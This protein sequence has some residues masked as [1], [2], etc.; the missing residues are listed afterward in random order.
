MTT[1]SSATLP[2]IN[3]RQD[4]DMLRISLQISVFGGVASSAVS[5]HTLTP[6]PLT[7]HGM[8]C[9]LHRFHTCTEKSH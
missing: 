1:W 8:A 6:Y 2:P 9:P 3:L 4:D 7:G 5:K